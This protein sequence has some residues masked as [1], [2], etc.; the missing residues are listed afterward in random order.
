VGRDTR[1]ATFSDAAASLA[2]AI[3]VFPGKLRLDSSKTL[4][5]ERMRVHREFLAA[6]ASEADGR[7]F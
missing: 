1:F 2:K 7:L 3:E 5:E 6:L 4:A